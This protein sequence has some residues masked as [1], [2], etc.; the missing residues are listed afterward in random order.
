[1]VNTKGARKKI[2]V[3]STGGTIASVPGPAGL[4]PG[5]TGQGLL[6]RVSEAAEFAEVD[7]VEL[8]A[9]DSTNLLPEHWQ[10][11]AVTVAERRGRYDGFV[12]THGTDTMAYS[13]GAL[14]LMLEHIDCP[15]ILTGSQLPMEAAGTDAVEN[16]LAAF[17]G[18]ASG[19]AGI[20]LAFGGLL[21]S[22]WTVRKL[23]S[24]QLTG[25]GSIARPPVAVFNGERYEWKWQ[26]PKPAGEFR[27]VTALDDSVAVLKL[28]PGTSPTLLELMVEAGLHGIIIE[29]YGAGGVPNSESPRNFL[30]ALSHAAAKGVRIVCTTQCV[31]DGAYLN[32]YE[33]GVMA[34]RMGC[35]SGGYLHT[36]LLVPALM[37]ALAESREREALERYLASVERRIFA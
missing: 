35:V 10:K 33:V 37:L 36:E 21:H 11:M 14:C 27:L 4:R 9:L 17:H 13:A 28:V 24:R 2:C 23:Y 5:L 25:F 3:I 29:G 1:M 34:L 30:P 26:P 31:Y 22:A 16:L 20:Y 32:A 15:V 12:I 7:C 6:A 19:R 8:M 18:A